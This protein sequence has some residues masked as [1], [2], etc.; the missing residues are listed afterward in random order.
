[1]GPDRMLGAGG[2]LENLPVY[3]VTDMVIV[4]FVV[5]LEHRAI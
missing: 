1:M 2:N 5:A 3:G 4:N